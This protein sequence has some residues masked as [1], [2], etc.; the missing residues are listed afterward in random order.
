MYL[1]VGIISRIPN[2]GV[3]SSISGDIHLSFLEGFIENDF[4]HKLVVILK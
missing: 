4:A 1:L 3:L 2:H